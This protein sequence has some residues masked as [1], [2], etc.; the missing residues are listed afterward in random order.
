MPSSIRVAR[1][2]DGVPAYAVPLPPETLPPVAPR[3]LESAWDRARDAAAAERWGPPRRLLF[4]REDG[5]PQEMLLADADAA[6][7]AERGGRRPMTSASCAA[8][9]CACGCL[10]WSR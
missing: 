2:P 7:W 4:R 3:D 10:P 6:C 9:R 8:C 5:T 1:S